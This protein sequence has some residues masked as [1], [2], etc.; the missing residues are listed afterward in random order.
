MNT[1]TAHALF[2]GCLLLA[3]AWASADVAVYRAAETRG[4]KVHFGDPNRPAVQVFDGHVRVAVDLPEGPVRVRAYL[5]SN[6]S[7]DVFASTVC[8]LFTGM[9][10][11]AMPVK[12]LS[13]DN[14]LVLDFWPR[15]PGRT[16]IHVTA[17]D[18]S[19]EARSRLLVLKRD[20]AQ[21]DGVTLQGPA[22]NMDALF[23][24]L[25]E[26]LA[27]ET[28][29]SDARASEMPVVALERIEIEPLPRPTLIP[30]VAQVVPFI[31]TAA[32]SIVIGENFDLGP[33]EVW[34]WQPPANSD[35]VNAGLSALGAPLP[36][37]PP[38]GARRAEIL[39]EDQQVL[40]VYLPDDV[41]WVKNRHGWSEPVLCH[42]AKPHWI[43]DE[44]VEP[45]G[46]LFLY[47]YGLRLPG[48]ESHLALQGARGV[49]PPETFTGPTQARTE[50]DPYLV[51]FRIPDDA[52][53]GQYALWTNNGAAGRYGWVMAGTL[54]IRP[55]A[56][57]N[58]QVF[59]V[60]QYGADGTGAR[61]DRAA[62][63]AAMQAAR[64]AGGG[65]V[66]L[67]P[68]RYAVEETVSLEPGVILRGAG[69]NATTLEGM[70]YDPSRVRWE[71]EYAGR[72]VARAPALVSMA[73]ESG[74]EDLT[75]RGAPARGES[76]F[77][78]YV[79]IMAR[80]RRNLHIA[81][82]RI[83]GWSEDA[84]HDRHFYSHA[85]EILRC[86]R[87]RIVDNDIVG[88]LQAR[89]NYRLDIVGNRIREAPAENIAMADYGN[90]KVWLD[91]NVLQEGAG[92][93]LIM[94]GA[95][96]NLVRRNELH[97]KF[98][99]DTNSGEG[100]LVHGGVPA[101]MTGGGMQ[102]DL[103]GAPVVAESNTLTVAEAMEPGRQ[104]GAT[105]VIVRG[106]GFGQYAIVEDNDEHT[107]I[108]DRAW[109][110]VPDTTSRFTCRANFTEMTMHA[111]STVGHNPL[112]LYYD[113]IACIV[114]GQR[115]AFGRFSHTS[116]AAGYVS[117]FGRA[118]TL[119]L[120]GKMWFNLM[121]NC[122]F[123]GAPM[124]FNSEDY[125]VSEPIHLH[126]GDFANVFV[127][128]TISRPE[129]YR[130][131]YGIGGDM[132]HSLRAAI[133]LWADR[134][135]MLR[136]GELGD[137]GSAFAPRGGH[138]G[139]P[140]ASHLVFADNTLAEAWLGF[141]I[142][143][144]MKKTFLLD[145]TLRNIRQPWRDQGW[146]TYARGNRLLTLDEQGR[147]SVEILPEQR[148]D[149]TREVMTADQFWD[150]IYMQ[151]NR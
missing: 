142:G 151:E 74:I 61:C 3:A 85:M 49:L 97:N 122:S 43:S 50:S 108:L 134:R 106:R 70:G 36:A 103:Y 88:Q 57:R 100:F 87:V 133:S 18:M 39:D 80:G 73:D 78:N 98:R 63:T 137:S 47:G 84:R 147:D 32:P 92:R 46:D 150:R 141:D 114:D 58:V 53:P 128:N 124:D 90:R 31:R 126:G 66:Y 51:H 86:H 95:A 52:E 42:A 41:V 30:E 29:V 145:N 65:V 140:R 9:M 17:G 96:Q 28:A 6:L 138:W 1:W 75:A 118:W 2:L 123:S 129:L 116:G 76:H 38:E 101:A 27:D 111:N 19:P 40:T 10:S 14:P 54:T 125:P 83:L 59:D 104:V 121:H 13:V 119:G 35:E 12:D 89:R 68:G 5:R 20:A 146:L 62:I 131:A 15:Q 72:N 82:C 148:S 48:G 113:M 4:E 7:D 109:K 112:V 93:F 8:R 132:A 16:Y 110:V 144:L 34:T 143:P 105:V 102:P 107:L 135:G 115:Q 81:R 139:W 71:Q 77:P 117:E 25:I 94:H 11:A 130:R 23:G 21:S 79:M 37:L 149:F 127:G 45:G 67:P 69:R 22:D 24:E 60:M 91:S 56:E 64:D 44:T 55:G 26:E 33:L 136:G 120:P 99:N